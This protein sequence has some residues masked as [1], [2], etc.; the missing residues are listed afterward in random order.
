M[1]TMICYYFKVMI[2]NM[3]NNQFQRQ[4]THNPQHA[5]PDTPKPNRKLPVV[6]KIVHRTYSSTHVRSVLCAFCFFDRVYLR[7]ALACS[8]LLLLLSLIMDT[9]RENTG[10]ERYTAKV[11][12]THFPID[13]L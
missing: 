4:C 5:A 7:D 8:T 9:I 10:G 12:T 1:G 13:K 2:M 11:R 3:L 6:H